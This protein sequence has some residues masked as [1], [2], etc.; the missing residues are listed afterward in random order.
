M[1][2]AM[3]A[4][5]AISVAIRTFNKIHPLNIYSSSI[6]LKKKCLRRGT[7]INS[8]NKQLLETIWPLCFIVT[9]LLFFGIAG[10]AT[11]SSIRA[12]VSGESYWSK[13]QKEAVHL[14]HVYTE[15]HDKITY[16]RF[17]QEISVPLNDQAARL[18]LQ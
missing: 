4:L 9:L 5:A 8:I 14:L 3:Q 12:F 18:E 10:M 15:N 7:K 6:Y 2:I 17:L 1:Y 13:S 11:L 16:E